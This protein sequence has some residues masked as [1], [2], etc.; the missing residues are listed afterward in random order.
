MDRGWPQINQKISRRDG[1]L[2]FV[3]KQDLSNQ[4]WETNFFTPRYILRILM[5][6][7]FIVKSIRIN[8]RNRKNI[9]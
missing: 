7:K 6:Q 3:S 8:S 2:L 1:G 4:A 9:I 5:Y